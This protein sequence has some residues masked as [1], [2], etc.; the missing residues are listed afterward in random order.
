MEQRIIDESGWIAN[1][2]KIREN[3]QGNQ[4]QCVRR[5]PFAIQTVY[6]LLMC[7]LLSK[8]NIKMKN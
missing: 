1:N 2:N 6:K 3:T 5:V 4:E 8:R 7:F